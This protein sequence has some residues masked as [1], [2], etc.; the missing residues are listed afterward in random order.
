MRFDPAYTSKKVS[1][2]QFSRDLILCGEAK[3]SDPPT[4]EDAK[5]LLSCRFGLP[6]EPTKLSPLTTNDDPDFMQQLM[7]NPN[8]PAYMKRLPD[9]YGRK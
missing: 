8:L 6:F 7:A 9:Y 2:E 3:P 5:R 1:I 4:A